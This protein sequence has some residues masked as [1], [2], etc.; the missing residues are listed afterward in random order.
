LPGEP[1][2][3]VVATPPGDAQ[4]RG[5]A[6]MR[7]RTRTITSL[8]RAEACLAFC[9]I[10]SVQLFQRPHLLRLLASALVPFGEL[11]QFLRRW[12]RLRKFGDFALVL[13]D[14]F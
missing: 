10:A 14:V 5:S 12:L 1:V 7:S 9:A 8:I 6:F 4:E 13:L 3:A 2:L 11:A